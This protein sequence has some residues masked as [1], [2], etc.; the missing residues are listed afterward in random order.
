[1]TAQ[2]VE[3]RTSTKTGPVRPIMRS[4]EQTGSYFALRVDDGMRSY[5]SGEHDLRQAEKLIERQTDTLIICQLWDTIPGL[6]FR[7]Q[8]EWTKA[9]DEFKG[10][11]ARG[12]RSQELTD[13]EYRLE[14]FGFAVD[15]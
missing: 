12:R 10:L 13:A 7:G 8:P 5:S 9:L 14:Q 15:R 3:I 6:Q 1:M 11:A 4:I 2:Q